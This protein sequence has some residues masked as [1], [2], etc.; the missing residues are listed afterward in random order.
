MNYVRATPFIDEI[1]LALALDGLAA[2]R[3]GEGS[4]TDVLAISL[5]ATDI[6]GHRYGPDSREAHDNVLRLDQSL[7]RFLDSLFVLR[8]ASRVAVVLTADHGIGSF[9]E[10]QPGFGRAGGPM[11]VTLAAPMDSLTAWLT[12]R[13]ITQPAAFLEN[14]ALLVN[15]RALDAAN[16]NADSVA[17][18]FVRLV[19]GEP[20]VRRAA[21]LTTL[22]RSD[23]VTDAA[24]RR[25]LHMF[26][27]GSFVVATVTL[28]PGSVWGTRAAAEHGTPN[29]YDA[30]VPLI[31]LGP[32]FRAG[33]HTE[34]VRVVDLAPTLAE[35]AG[36]KPSE[37]VDGRVLREVLEGERR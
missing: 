7:G 6:I 25:W 32:W 37:R 18:R 14:G 1:T 11:H 34:P 2:M 15:R 33:R 17:E 13:G 3:L 23:T 20:G 35:V 8:D 21:S 16:V 10:L 19:Q 22:A 24:A 26:A 36:V 30:H 29:D 4:S 31:F 12:S 5:S 27:P 9:P 28:T